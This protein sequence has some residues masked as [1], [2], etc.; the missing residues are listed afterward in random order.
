MSFVFII[1]F[2]DFME[3]ISASKAVLYSM[4]DKIK[5]RSRTKEMIVIDTL[6]ITLVECPSIVDSIV[7]Y[8]VFLFCCNIV[9]SIRA[10][11]AIIDANR[12]SVSL[13]PLSK[14]GRGNSG[15]LI[16]RLS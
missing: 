1:F 6:F 2:F 7:V 14:N 11:T 10:A 9:N 4:R 3:D 5:T 16:R 12:S 8:H 15:S 13:L